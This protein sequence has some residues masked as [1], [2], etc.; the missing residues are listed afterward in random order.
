MQR[1]L[2]IVLLNIQKP[3][4]I[5]G[6]ANTLCTRDSFKRVKFYLY[7]CGDEILSFDFFLFSTE[8][9]S[10]RIFVFHDDSSHGG[11]IN[12][13]LNECPIFADSSWIHSFSSLIF[14]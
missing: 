3:P 11:L 1:T 9:C 6:F 10:S 5:R 12:F 4:I 13:W 2:V 7:L 8:D 14:D